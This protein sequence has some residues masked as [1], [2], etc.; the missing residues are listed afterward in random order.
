MN[1][2]ISTAP[3]TRLY[4]EKLPGLD[5]EAHVLQQTLRYQL[6]IR[7]LKRVRIFQCYDFYHPGADG[8]AKIRDQVFSDPAAERV[9]T[10]AEFSASE[11]PAADVRLNVEYLPGQYDARAE[12]ASQAV[13]LVLD[14]PYAPVK[15]TRV[16]LFY[17][18]GRTSRSLEAIRTYLVNPVESRLAGDALPEVLEFPLSEPA[19]VQQLVGFR[20]LSRPE[21]EHLQHRLG[22]AMLLPDLELMQRYFRREEQRDPSMAELRV[23]DTYWSDHCRHTTFTTSIDSVEIEAAPQQPHLAESYQLFRRFHGSGACSLM[24]LALAGMRELRRE[25]RLED[26]EVSEEVNA[27]GLH[28]RV[29]TPA[30]DADWLLMFK[31]ETHNHPT[32][33][34]PFGGAAT[35][36]GGAIRD[37]LSGRAYVYQAMRLTGS[38]DPR[39]PLSE[40]RPGKLPQRVITTEAA[41]G[42][43][44]YGNQVGLATGYVRECYHPGFVAKRM[45][46]GAVIGAVPLVQVRRERPQPGDIV[47]LVGGATG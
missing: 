42:Y 17:G 4:V 29:D 38:G 39:R 32:E 23:L 36:L 27:A 10:S 26:L 21:L 43:S 19:P 47:L 12:A 34:E 1:Q 5:G 6:G 15:T 45:E 44:S 11:L 16:Y 20:Q 46:V 18:I 33:I 3:V 37:P 2:A 35:C 30:G 41:R 7:S 13:S 25:G 28:I 24:D 31:N 40:T 14:R 22:L 8:F 9:F